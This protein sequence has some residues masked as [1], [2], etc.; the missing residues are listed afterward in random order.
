MKRARDHHAGLTIDQAVAE[1]SRYM[2]TS[3][4]SISRLE[5]LP[6]GPK[7]RSQRQLAC[8]ALVLYGVDPAELDLGRRD[9]PP[10]IY[11]QLRRRRPSFAWVT[12][13]ELR[14]RHLQTTSIY[15]RRANLDRLRDA[16]AGR[17]YLA[18]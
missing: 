10:A 5:S 4:G 11:A 15:L 18:A 16:M 2:L 1:I 6:D 13:D 14:R 3:T 7:S 8:I 12:A 17:R 9:L